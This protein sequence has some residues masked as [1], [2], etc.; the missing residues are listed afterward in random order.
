M[1]TSWLC[2]QAMEDRLIEL[3]ALQK[4]LNEGTGFV[5]V[6]KLYSLWISCLLLIN[7]NFFSPSSVTEA[8]DKMQRDLV[9]AKESLTKILTSKDVKETVCPVLDHLTSLQVY[10]LFVSISLVHLHS[11]LMVQLLEMVKQNQLNRSLLTLLD[12]NIANAHRG[13]Q[14]IAI[15]KA[16]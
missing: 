14:V 6:H 11:V 2:S 5:R 1:K 16:S 10:L 8:Y 12:E 13:N 3:E 4:A 9:T 15:E 7:H